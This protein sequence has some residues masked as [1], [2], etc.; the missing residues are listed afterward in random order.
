M[1]KIAKKKKKNRR[2]NCE[3]AHCVSNKTMYHNSFLYQW[4]FSKHKWNMVL[5]YIEEVARIFNWRFENPTSFLTIIFGALVL[6]WLYHYQC[7]KDNASF[8]CEAGV[9]MSFRLACLFLLADDFP[10]LAVFWL[11]GIF[12]S[13]AA[14]LCDLIC[15]WSF[16]MPGWGSLC[17]HG[18]YSKHTHCVKDPFFV[19]KLFSGCF[20]L[21]EHSGQK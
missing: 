18:H 20:T 5:K 3:S 19:Q 13:N 17:V 2:K 9:K 14:A 15:S 21:N 11:M 7:H 4:S 1:T 16:L 12:P 8:S 6:S 10:P